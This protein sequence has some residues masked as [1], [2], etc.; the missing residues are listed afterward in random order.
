[1]ISFANTDNQSLKKLIGVFLE[2]SGFSTQ[3]F[4][5]SLGSYFLNEESREFAAF[6]RVT[7]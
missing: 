7:Q 3:V 2:K 6:W 1:M 5:A 4:P